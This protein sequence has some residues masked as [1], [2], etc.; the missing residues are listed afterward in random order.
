M[1]ARDTCC[2]MAGSS[3]TVIFDV[4]A[5]RIFHQGNAGHRLISLYC[6]SA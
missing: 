6:Q 4:V 5:K 3:G 2:A 1:I